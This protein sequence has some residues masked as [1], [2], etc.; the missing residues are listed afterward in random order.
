MLTLNEA[1]DDLYLA[2]NAD[3]DQE[4]VE[5]DRLNF[6]NQVGS[7][8]ERRVCDLAFMQ[9][10]LNVLA[11]IPK[12]LRLVP[13]IR[14]MLL[15]NNLVRDGGLQKVFEILQENPNI[16][17]LD[18][19]ANDLSDSSLTQ[20]IDIIK[21]S[22]LVS[23]Q[24][25]RR[26][27][28][29]QENQYSQPGIAAILDM[30]MARNT[31]RCFGVAGIPLSKHRRR[32]PGRDFAER[33][34]NLLNTCTRMEVLDISWCGLTAADQSTLAQGLTRK[35][36]LKTLKIAHN[37][38][39]TGVQIINSIS[40]LSRLRNLDISDCG[41]GEQAVRALAKQ[42][43]AGW[44]LIR[45][46]IS[47]NPIGTAGISELL[48]V[49]H[50]NESLCELNLSDTL[51]ESVIAADMRDYLMRTKV[52]RT[53][54][55]SNNHLGDAIADVF[56]EVL[57]GQDTIAN[58]YLGNCRI[59]DEGSTVLCFALIRNKTLLSLS[60][61]D[62]FLSEDNGL[63]LIEILTENGILRSLD[64]S[65]NQIDHFAMEGIE[66][67]MKRNRKTAH[68]QYLEVLREKYIRL[69][70]QKAK[71]P[72]VEA[73]L[74]ELAWQNES[75]KQKIDKVV[76]KT[77]TF[78]LDTIG[79]L[80]GLRKSIVSVEDLIAGENKTIQELQA[81]ITDLE[82][83]KQRE[84]VEAR[85]KTAREKQSMELAVQEAERIEG[86]TQKY[87]DDSKN[88]EESLRKDIE[89]VESMLRE[90]RDKVRDPDQLRVWE[91]PVDPFPIESEP[92]TP[93]PELTSIAASGSVESG[94][95]SPSSGKLKRLRMKPVVRKPEVRKSSAK[96]GAV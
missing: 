71:I 86:V 79:N 9:C 55:L 19:G 5:S 43:T 59:T 80:D 61:K 96:R 6:L 23:L 1:L 54:D 35:C 81:G 50:D 10:G 53:I 4:G 27:P 83:T 47:R 46:N 70:I 24:I 2:R 72:N 38:F 37:K 56:A 87:I 36:P 7:G 28:S 33:I 94:L 45:L 51:L 39:K 30:V 18:I 20:M 25:G 88:F 57:P 48:E 14:S 93:P 44:G 3:K 66:A 91:I 49:L 75:V 42:F 65:S 84:I 15:Y 76:D 40:Q 8:F 34:A 31:L 68:D 26:E 41:L 63:D 74:A 58:V 21:R 64:V 95:E 32:A 16:V 60:L 77:Q 85:E 12:V 29:L 13:K 82:V 90:V 69:S 67:I 89:L 78:E 92:E 17:V 73:E 22:D 52:L 62:N 11:R